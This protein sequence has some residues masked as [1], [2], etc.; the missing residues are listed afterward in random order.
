MAAVV[1]FAHG[2]AAVGAEISELLVTHARD[3]APWTAAY[4]AIHIVVE[5]VLPAIFPS[6]YDVLG[7]R[8][9][10]TAASKGEGGAQAAPPSR[11][12]LAVVARTA[13]VAT[14]MAA[15]VVSLS[16]AALWEGEIEALRADT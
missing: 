1:E 9:A 11:R 5:F 10:L 8:A 13:A 3:W 14:S 6:I 16:L 7:R 15:Y 12:E 2:V 4:V